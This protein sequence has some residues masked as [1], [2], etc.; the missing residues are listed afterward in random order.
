VHLVAG[1]LLIVIFAASAQALGSLPASRVDAAPQVTGQNFKVTYEGRVTV[2]ATNRTSFIYTVTGKGV[3]PELSHFELQIPTCTPLL[4]VAAYNP[5]EAVRFGVDPTTGLDGIKW[6]RPL[7]V[8]ESRTY[9]VTLSGNVEE[10][11]TQAAVKTGSEYFT[12][13]VPGPACPTTSIN[14]IDVEKYISS[15][16]VNWADVDNGPGALAPVGGDVWFRF[17]V[18][19]NGDS[20]LT[21]VE[22]TD[23]IFALPYCDIPARLNP[24]QS[25]EC[26]I[27][28]AAAIAGQHF[29]TATVRALSGNVTVSD[30]D[31][32]L[33][34]RRHPT[35]RHDRR[36]GHRAGDQRQYA[37]HRWHER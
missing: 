14:S 20:S 28:P 11:T 8:E 34:R 3:P 33:S 21:N 27:G 4:Q 37:H 9:T 17:V 16:L 2:R 31:R 24:G 22:L 29:S 32:A 18:R 26:N 5:T 35:A 36:R 30:S 13:A 1:L 23:S 19:N 6:D 25:V 12:V 15:D 10:G 7:Q